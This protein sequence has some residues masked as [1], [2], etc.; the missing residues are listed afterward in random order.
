MHEK[1]RELRYGPRLTVRS[2]NRIGQSTFV[3]LWFSMV[4]SC[5]FSRFIKPSRMLN[6][7]HVFYLCLHVFLSFWNV[8]LKYII[9]WRGSG[10]GQGPQRRSHTPISDTFRTSNRMK[11]SLLSLASYWLNQIKLSEFVPCTQFHLD[12]SNTHPNLHGSFFL[13]L[14]LIVQGSFSIFD[15]WF[16][17]IS[18]F[19]T[20]ISANTLCTEIGICVLVFLFLLNDMDGDLKLF[21]FWIDG[22]LKLDR[23]QFCIVHRWC[24][25]FVIADIFIILYIYLDLMSFHLIVMPKLWTCKVAHCMDCAPN[26]I[27]DMKFVSAK[28]A[29]PPSPVKVIFKCVWFI[30][31]Q[32]N[33]NL[34]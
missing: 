17:K 34:S 33:W 32:G 10:Y 13:L 23:H 9:L 27:S 5:M 29:N 28:D 7:M 30:Y 19:C 14:L 8:I 20:D 11:F 12:S 26:Y 15:F 16:E 3:S 25:V 24:S 18:Y 31:W 22:A 2:I 4:K 1:E 6:S 21:I